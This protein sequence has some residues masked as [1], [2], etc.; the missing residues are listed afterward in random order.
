M[1]GPDNTLY[2]AT[3]D[4]G[5]IFAVAPDGKGDV[6]YTGDETHIRSLA[7]DGKG[8]LIA[9]TE[10]N[11]WVMRIPLA[12][13][14]PAGAK[15]GERSA[16]VLYETPKREITAILPDGS[17]NLYVA[18][19]GEKQRNASAVQAGYGFSGRCP[20]SVRHLRLLCLSLTKGSSSVQTNAQR[21]IRH[22]QSLGAI[23]LR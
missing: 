16:Y 10:P 17:G 18:A 1:I 3:G 5:K 11:G 8:N 14:P 12:G 7:L 4:T 19:I 22:L 9:G 23:P 15:A 6:F 2:V 20:R 13:D 21:R